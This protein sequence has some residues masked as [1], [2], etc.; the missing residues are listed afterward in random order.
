MPLIR[1]AEAE[2]SRKTAPRRSGRKKI[3]APL[4]VGCAGLPALPITP[5][6]I[7]SRMFGFKPKNPEEHRYYLLPGQGR[8]AKRK[9]RVHM[10]ASL[11]TAALVAAGLSALMWYANENR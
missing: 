11:V 4:L 5:P 10:I 2:G 9:R 7:L 3:T 6:S 1:Y 8:G